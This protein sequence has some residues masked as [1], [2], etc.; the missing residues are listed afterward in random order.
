MVAITYYAVNLVLYVLGPL[1][2]MYC[3][4]K[5]MMAAVATPVVLIGVWL[6]VERIRKHME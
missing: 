2:K 5:V 3:V 6:M 1:E 4:P